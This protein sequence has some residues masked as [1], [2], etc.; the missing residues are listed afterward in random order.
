M[1]DTYKVI[2]SDASTVAND[3]GID[4]KLTTWGN[5]ENSLSGSNQGLILDYI[6]HKGGCTKEWKTSTVAF[7]IKESKYKVTVRNG[8]TMSASDHSPIVA[9]I[10]MKR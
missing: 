2:N 4:S 5:P 10:S 9:E 7:E 8:K 3:K 1:D 6:M